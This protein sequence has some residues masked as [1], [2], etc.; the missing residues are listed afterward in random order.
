MHYSVH[1]RILCIPQSAAPQSRGR[2][3]VVGI[4]G[5]KV[6]FEWPKVITTVGLND[7]VDRHI[8]KKKHALNSLQN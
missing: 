2:C 7:C 3:Y 4:R 5:P 1:I 6:G 8:I